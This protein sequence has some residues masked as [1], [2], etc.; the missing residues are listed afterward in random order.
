M[1]RPAPWRSIM[2]TVVDRQPFTIGEATVDPVSREASWPSGKERLQPQTLKVLVALVSRRG[3]VV[4]RD[5]L[6]ELCWDG[7]AVSDDVINRAIL[8]L[9]HLAERAGG[10][11]I[12]T[13]PRTGYRLMENGKSTSSGNSTH[14]RGLIVGAVAATVA[15]AGLAGW[16]TLKR[17]PAS[18]GLP[19]TPSISVVP[20]AIEATTRWCGRSP[21]VRPH[22]CPEC[23]LKAALRSSAMIPRPRGAIPAPIISSREACGAPRTW[24]RPMSS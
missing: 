21:T 6:V 9:R 15:I 5:E 1:N 4:T 12:E 18:Q 20:F 8:L 16:A 11:A 24:L 19:P 2:T 22:R 23:C 7:R 13:V 14:R 3:E 10:F 17:P